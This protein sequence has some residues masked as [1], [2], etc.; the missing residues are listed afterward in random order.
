[1]KAEAIN[2]IVEYALTV[3][4]EAGKVNRNKA[5]KTAFDRVEQVHGRVTL[6][7]DVKKTLRSEIDNRIKVLASIGKAEVVKQIG[8]FAR[9]TTDLELEQGRRIVTVDTT[10]L[11]PE[12][13]VIKFHGLLLE[14]RGKVAR[15]E[16]GIA[17][18]SQVRQERR[19]M[20]AINTRLFEMRDDMSEQMKKVSEF[21]NARNRERTEAKFT[22]AVTNATT[23]VT[24]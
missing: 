6:T 19:I 20:N 21:V 5:F 12:Q 15:S 2:T 23:P 3:A 8:S 16:T 18:E 1:M 4:V 9:V 13:E 22:E 11:T 10:I 17:T 24:A 7:D 14:L